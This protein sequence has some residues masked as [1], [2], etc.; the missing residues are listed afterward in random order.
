MSF[1]QFSCLIGWYNLQYLNWEEHFERHIRYL[2]KQNKQ[3]S[4][5]CGLRSKMMPQRKR[6]TLLVLIEVII[7][8]LAFGELG[9]LTF[10][11][12]GIRWH[13]ITFGDIRLH[14]MGTPSRSQ[15]RTTL[16]KATAKTFN[17]IRSTVTCSAGRMSSNAIEYHPNVKCQNV[18]MSK[19]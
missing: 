11:H 8:I 3:K 18:K 16:P 15:M 19:C 10:G 7:V 17:D 14:S 4:Y 5:F 2:F 9:I 1:V 12:F 6:L 13:S